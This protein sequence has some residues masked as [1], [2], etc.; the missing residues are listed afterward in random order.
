MSGACGLWMAPT[1]ANVSMRDREESERLAWSRKREA[2]LFSCRV[3]RSSQVQIG[4]RCKVVVLFSP[5]GLVPIGGAAERWDMQVGI[6]SSRARRCI[7]WLNCEW[8]VVEMVVWREGKSKECQ[9]R[10]Q[11][12]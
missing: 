10:K 7:L 6:H 2:V 9:E 12:I 4:P 3:V 5:V 8:I 1:A 11:G